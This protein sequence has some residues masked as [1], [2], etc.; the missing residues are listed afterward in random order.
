MFKWLL[1][2][3]FALW[4]F[5]NGGLAQWNESK[6]DVHSKLSDDEQRSAL[7]KMNQTSFSSQTLFIDSILAIILKNHSITRST[8][9][10]LGSADNFASETSTLVQTL[11][12]VNETACNRE[13]HQLAVERAKALFKC[14]FANISS[15]FGEFITRTVLF[16]ILSF[17]DL[18]MELDFT[19]GK[20][21]INESAFGLPNSWFEF[22]SYKINQTTNLIDMNELL[23]FV[24]L[25]NPKLI[26]VKTN[27][28]PRK[29]NWRQLRKT[30]DA[31]GAY[32]LSDIS[33]ISALIAAET[34]PSPIPYCHAVITSTY[35]SL[36]GPLGSLVM[37]NDPYVARQIASAPILQRSTVAAAQAV[38]FHEAS[39]LD[40][41]LWSKSIVNNA[42]ALSVRLIQNGIP[43]ITGGT[44][45]HLVSIDLKPLKLTFETAEQA[46]SSCYISL[47]RISPPNDVS[48]L[49]FGIT[50]LTCRGMTEMQMADLADIITEILFKLSLSRE[51][52]P[53]LEAKARK[54]VLH[55]A[56]KF[57]VFYGNI[58]PFQQSVQ[59]ITNSSSTA[60]L[61]TKLSKPSHER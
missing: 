5:P 36:R 20:R 25:C 37:T 12:A 52:S 16:S 46:L 55:L 53:K 58:V 61:P 6:K 13:I 30:A 18:V 2:H 35:E 29:I 4:P 22:V 3:L 43:T 14:K 41:K 44:D 11:S 40:F 34:L 39:S 21:F 32:L 56:F 42:K 47:G 48:C 50:S 51:V 23:K 19:H 17:G 38:A 31:V 28:Y 54:F 59:L 33:T 49:H 1:Q 8:N 57:P 10:L 7:R 24:T 9:L 45:N 27:S 60:S 26:F 15:N